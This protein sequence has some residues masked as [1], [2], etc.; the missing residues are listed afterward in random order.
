MPAINTN[1]NSE[2][3]R[4]WNRRMVTGKTLEECDHKLVTYLNSQDFGSGEFMVLHEDNGS[5]VNTG[6]DLPDGDTC[7]ISFMTYTGR[8]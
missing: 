5:G 3:N 8:L 6:Y 1:K 7:Y 2:V 4:G